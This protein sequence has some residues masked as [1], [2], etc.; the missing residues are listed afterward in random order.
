MKILLSKKYLTFPVNTQ[1]APKKICLRENG[2]WLFDF[3]CKLDLIAPNFTAYIDVARFAGKTVEMSIDPEM[4][5]S[6]GT[7]DEIDLPDLFHERLRPQ[8]HFT[9]PNG[10]NN[11][12]N[13]LILYEGMYH[14]FYQYNPAAT[15]WGNMHWGHAV[16]P[17]LVHWEHRDIALFP[18]E[19]GTMYSGSAIEDLHN[20]TG[21]RCNEHNPLLLF[22]T[23]AAD[24]NIPS[25]GKKT[26]QCLAYSTDG[27]VTFQK[28]AKNPVVEWVAAYN[29]DPK[30]VW[31]E[32]LG[33]YLMIF[34]TEKDQYHLMTSDNLLDWT[35]YTTLSI[36][37]D[38]E[39]PDPF[40]LPYKDKW[41]WVILG[42]YDRYVIGTFTKEGFSPVGK[43]KQLSY[44]P[45][46]YAAQSFSGLDTGEAIRI[47][48]LKP[49][50]PETPVSQQMGFP[51]Q[52][53]LEEH[54]GELYLAGQP[55]DN[56]RLLRE[57]SYEI[58]ETVLRSPQRFD[59]CANPVELSLE[60]P[61]PKNTVLTLMLFGFRM[62]V[63]TKNNQITFGGVKMPLS[64]EQKR[65]SL[66]LVVDRCTVECYADGG[67]FCFAT[68][69]LCDYN[70]PYVELSSDKGIPLDRFVC[71]TLS[72][73][74]SKKKGR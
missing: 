24:R 30:V 62:T 60:L 10:W 3:D 27:G 53:H 4:Q 21:F 52:M 55:H 45:Q 35:P 37:G 16:S 68:R 61:Y 43:V 65:I 1:A 54:E 28:Y 40:R 51:M 19:M 66:R 15:D 11:D 22:Y 73:M 34:Y 13:G 42:A 20:V 32:K 26:C 48:W 12:P 18:D 49:G 14:L 56:I 41:Y 17:D 36:E 29:R 31:V 67:I 38:W 58:K 57:I 50:I 74:Y 64:K 72:S 59:V 2:E 5:I 9:V 47:S 69:C 70:L 33:K 71:H 6:F 39:C 8:V 63:D 25:M 44:C 23:A 7:A 46:S